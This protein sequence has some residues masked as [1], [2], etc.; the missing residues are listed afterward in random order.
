MTCVARGALKIM[1]EFEK[2]H[3]VLMSTGKHGK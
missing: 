1:E 2:Y 3:P